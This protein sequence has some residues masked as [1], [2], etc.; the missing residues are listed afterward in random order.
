MLLVSPSG[1]AKDAA[2]HLTMDKTTSPTKNYPAQS[3]GSVRAEKP[4]YGMMIAI[5]K[6]ASMS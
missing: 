6:T 1:E 5:F 2:K 3:V 4:W